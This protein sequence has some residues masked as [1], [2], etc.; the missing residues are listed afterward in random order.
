MNHLEALGGMGVCAFNPSTWNG[1][2][3]RGGDEVDVGAGAGVWAEAR[4]P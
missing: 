4:G 3:S 2:D 1:S